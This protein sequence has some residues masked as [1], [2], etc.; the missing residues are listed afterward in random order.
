MGNTIYEVIVLEMYDFDQAN[1]MSKLQ[2][3]RR[4]EERLKKYLNENRG[5]LAN[6]EIDRIEHTIIGIRSEEQQIDQILNGGFY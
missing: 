3:L 1:Y 2:D 6:Y 5:V 4:E